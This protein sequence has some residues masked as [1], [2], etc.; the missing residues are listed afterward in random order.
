MLAWASNVVLTLEHVTRLLQNL[1]ETQRWAAPPGALLHKVW[2]VSQG[3][4]FL[5]SP[6]VVLTLLARGPHFENHCSRGPCG[7]GWTFR[8]QE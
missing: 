1:V 7:L 8:P 2:S 6:L 3:C 5:T 4:A